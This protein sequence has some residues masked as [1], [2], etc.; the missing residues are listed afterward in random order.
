MFTATLSPAAAAGAKGAVVVGETCIKAGEYADFNGYT[1]KV[2][3]IASASGG[4]DD[5]LLTVCKGAVCSKS[6]GFKDGD[7]KHVTV[8]SD[9]VKVDVSRVNFGASV[10]VTGVYALFGLKQGDS[11]DVNGFTIKCDAIASA[12]GG[13]A[14]TSLTA[15]KGAV[16]SASTGFKWKDTKTLNVGTDTVKITVTDIAYGVIITVAVG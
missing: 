7:S 2:D 13:P 5:A 11:V 8:G 6:T 9:T 10:C 16:C 14:D 1:V 3:S 4:T 15:C 12:S